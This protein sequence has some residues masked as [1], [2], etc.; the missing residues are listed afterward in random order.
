M[1][2]PSDRDDY[3]SVIPRS[4]SRGKVVVIEALGCEVFTII[5]T[6]LMA[7]EKIHVAKVLECTNML[8]PGRRACEHF[9]NEERQEETRYKHDNAHVRSEERRV[10]K[11]CPV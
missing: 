11:E 5:S 8:E 4:R 10:G 1:V 7:R 9:R 3:M 2:S 6:Y